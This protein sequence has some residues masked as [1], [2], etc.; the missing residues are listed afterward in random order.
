M[1]WLYAKHHILPS[2]YANM[3]PGEKVVLRAFYAKEIEETLKEQARLNKTMG[4][5]ADGK[6]H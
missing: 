1:Y 3:D 5:R 2:V 6:N 4:R